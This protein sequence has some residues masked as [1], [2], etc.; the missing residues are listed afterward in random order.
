MPKSERFS[1]P[2]ALPPQIG[3]L[4]IGWSLHTQRSTL[5]VRGLVTPT[6]V[7]LPVISAGL[8]PANFTPLDLKLMRGNSATLKKSAV[9]RCSSRARGR[10]PLSLS[11]VEIDADSIVSS[12]DPVL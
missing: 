6:M 10:A 9:R 5:K 7:R 3:F 8:S 1:V 11:P 4:L 12:A 2:E